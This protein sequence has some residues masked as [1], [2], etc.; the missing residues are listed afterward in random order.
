MIN[1]FVT[2]RSSRDRPPSPQSAPMARWTQ[3]LRDLFWSEF[4]FFA[5]TFSNARRDRPFK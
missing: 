2:D 5:F 4:T 3:F 1:A